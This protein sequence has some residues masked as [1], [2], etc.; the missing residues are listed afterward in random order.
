[1]LLKSVCR[2][3]NIPSRGI[4]LN[5]TGKGPFHKTTDHLWFAQIRIAIKR[6]WLFA[7]FDIIA[8]RKPSL[9]F[10]LALLLFNPQWIFYRYASRV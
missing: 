9:L 10:W 7:L 8:V 6:L 4:V 2:Q 5:N 1:M 3:L